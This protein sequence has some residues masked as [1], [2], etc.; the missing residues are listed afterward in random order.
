MAINLEERM[1]AK[2]ST[3]EEERVQCP[4]CSSVNIIPRQPDH[5][6]SHGPGHDYKCDTCGHYFDEA[7][8]DNGE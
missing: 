4:E 8:V 1:K 7:E 2:S 3:P 5:P 6:S